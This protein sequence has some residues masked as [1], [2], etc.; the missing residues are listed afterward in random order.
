[1]F[2]KASKI[3]G[4]SQSAGHIQVPRPDGKATKLFKQPKAAKSKSSKTLARPPVISSTKSSKSPSIYYT[5]SEGSGMS[6]STSEVITTASPVASPKVTPF[7]TATQEI[8]EKSVTT[9]SP[10]AMTNLTTAP[11][12]LERPPLTDATRPPLPDSDTRNATS[13]SEEPSPFMQALAALVG[14]EDELV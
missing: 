4:K 11:P 12:V 7:P 1:M 14:N 3:F 8:T 2:T 5:T 10:T 6:M 9:V 13:V